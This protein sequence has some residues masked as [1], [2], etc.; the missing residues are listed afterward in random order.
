MKRA[1]NTTSC[2]V[3]SLM[4]HKRPSRVKTKMRRERR[5]SLGPGMLL[6]R[7]S[8]SRA[9]KRKRC[10]FC[11]LFHFSC[12]KPLLG[13]VI[14]LVLPE[15]VHEHPRP[16]PLIPHS[17]LK[18]AFHARHSFLISSLT[19]YLYLGRPLT[20]MPNFLSCPPNCL[21]SIPISISSSI[22]LLH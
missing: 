11:L 5:S 1:T 17:T 18:A 9:T 20:P 3:T 13:I 8:R 12:W 4:K 16:S 7:K 2:S 21:I 14:G 15:P 6:G 10:V 19:S 22:P